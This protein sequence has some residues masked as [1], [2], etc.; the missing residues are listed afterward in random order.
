MSRD[1]KT[2]S[3]SLCF[4]LF[5]CFT[6]KCCDKTQSSASS[7]S[8][9]ST[10]PF[11]PAQTAFLF[12]HVIATY[13]FLS[14]MVSTEDEFLER[15]TFCTSQ[16]A[17]PFLFRQSPTRPQIRCLKKRCL[18]KQEISKQEEWEFCMYRQRKGDR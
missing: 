17:A 4:G 7:I 18:Y 15:G 10:A 13:S 8:K 5:F 9:W 1:P 6:D 12:H 14:S 16:I 3:G 11:H 2:S